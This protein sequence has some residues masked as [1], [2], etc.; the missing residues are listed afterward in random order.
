MYDSEELKTDIKLIL[1][2]INKRYKRTMTS[3]ELYE[4]TRKFWVIGERRSKAKYAVATYKGLTREVYEID[5]WM[6]EDYNGG[7]RWAFEGRQ[8]TDSKIINELRYKSI[9]SY[10]P[11]GAA[12]PIKYFN[13]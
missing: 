11:K 12:N 8:V 1:T 9:K 7:K 5:R 13:C 6:Q 2:N 3:E 4:A 10:F